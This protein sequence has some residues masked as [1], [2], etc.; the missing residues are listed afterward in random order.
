[1][2]I[3]VLQMD[4]RNLRMWRHCSV[5]SSYV[6]LLFKQ[7]MTEQVETA[8]S[9]LADEILRLREQARDV[10]RRLTSQVVGLSLFSCRGSKVA[11]NY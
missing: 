8:N 2:L 9:L 6:H 7:R 4:G 5:C 11:D 1:M 3:S 10:D